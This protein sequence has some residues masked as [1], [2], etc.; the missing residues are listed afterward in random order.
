MSS[1]NKACCTLPPVQT[2]YKPKGTFEDVGGLKSYVVGPKDSKLAVLMMYDIFGYWPQTQ[3][4]A[5]LLSEAMKARVV[6]P[7]FF[8][9]KPWPNEAFPPRNEEEGK[10]LQEFFSTVAE[11]NG[12]LQD[13]N[14]VTNALKSQGVQKFGLYGTCWGAKAAIQACGAGTPYSG[15][16][17]MHPAMVAVEDAKKLAVPV[18]FFPSKDEPAN[19]VKAFWDAVQPNTSI[20]SK[21]QFKHYDNMHHGFAA[22]RADLKNQENYFAFQDVYTRAA[23]FLCSLM[24]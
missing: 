15:V 17:Q 11:F 20:A 8:R 10:K 7:D 13:L 14:T 9:G 2:D 16:V 18:A 5:D 21:S 6:M 4:G 19:D 3:Q 23:D 1:V 24:C 12:R 22:A